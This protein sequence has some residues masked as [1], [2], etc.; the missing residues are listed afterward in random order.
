MFWW[1]FAIQPPPPPRLGS[2]APPAAS[3]PER[4]PNRNSH[5]TL[6]AG[7]HFDSSNWVV[8]LRKPSRLPILDSFR[9]IMIDEFVIFR[10]ARAR[11]RCRERR[12]LVRG[13]NVFAMMEFCRMRFFFSRR[14]RPAAQCARPGGRL[15][16]TR[17][18][19]NFLWIHKWKF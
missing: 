16:G 3:P 10:L 2:P 5:H 9:N 15:I 7:F 12:H 8:F 1:N 11:C 18:Q 19:K 6:F 14:T 17:R 4:G 13:K